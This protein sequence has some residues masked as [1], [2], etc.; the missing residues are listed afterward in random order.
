MT[1]S[2]DLTGPLNGLKVIDITTIVMG[3]FATQLMAEMGADVIKIEAPI[4]DT[5]RGIGPARHPEMG[6]MFIQTNRGKR[7]VVLD[8]KAP[9][10]RAS[11]IEL[12][13]TADVVVSNMR[14]AA[15]RRLGLTYETFSQS[16]PR[17]IF[18]TLSGYDERGPMAGKPAF[19]DLIQGGAGIPHLYKLAGST[20]PR[21]APITLSDRVV[22]LYGLSSILAALFS[23]EKTGRGQ[24]VEV[25]MFESMA[26]FV[27]GDHIGGA[28]FEPP[29]GPTGYPR[30][31]S[32]QRRPYPT[33]DGYVCTMIYNN[34][35]WRRFLAAIGQPDLFETDPRFAS[36]AT[37]TQHVDEI[38]QI[39]ADQMAE[40]TTDECIAMLEAAD[41]PV[42]R[43]NTIETL[44]DDP[45]LAASGLIQHLEH[46]TEGAIRVAGAPMRFSGTPIGPIRPAP[47]LGEH[48][49][50]VLGSPPLSG[51][52]RGPQAD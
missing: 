19:D 52:K 9:E 8:L 12:A 4:G 15:M 2:D 23:R 11:L 48:N 21:Y 27:L 26:H 3:P 39:I 20:T 32:E 50:E 14:P 6:W 7:S 46:P 13:S 30:L 45:Q 37:R 34:D 24:T 44:L 38:N 47:L 40:R 36:V 18:A 42:A 28:L 16:N 51:K 35:Q 31:L 41:L 10:E 33:R 49:I 29:L 17:V 25:P 5:L 22:G 43:L 1:V